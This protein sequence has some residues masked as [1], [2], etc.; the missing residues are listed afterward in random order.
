MRHVLGKALSACPKK[1]KEVPVYIDKIVEKEVVVRGLHVMSPPVDA[2][3]LY[4]AQR[5][6]KVNVYIEKEVKCN[7]F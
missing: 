3:F 7:T 1:E 6:K 4:N 5:E 2:L